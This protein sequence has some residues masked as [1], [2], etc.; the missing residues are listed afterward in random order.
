MSLPS[1]PRL[2]AVVLLGAALASGPTARAQP[3]L[4]AS[5]ASEFVG[6]VNLPGDS[7]DSILGLLERWTGKDLLRAQGLPNVTLT[8][9]LKDR[10]PK[11]QGVQALETLL[12]LNGIAVTPLGDRFLKVTP[13]NVAK[14]ESPEF[15][16]GST[17]GLPPSG[18]VASKLFQ[19]Q[20]LQVAEFMP[21]TAGLLNPAAGSPPII[22]DKANAALITDSITTLQRIET[23]V[24]RLD[25]PIL[26]STEPKF[27]PLRHATAADVVNRM[28]T[29]LSGP[30]A[31][32][33]GSATTYNADD[34]TN[35]LVL[36]TDARQHVFF[37]SLIAKLDVQ[38]DPNTRNAVIYLKHGSAPDV[39]N[40]LT[41]VVTG[42]M[43][44][45]RSASGSSGAQRRDVP[46]N[47]PAPAPQP[48]PL[49]ATVPALSL[50]A[51]DAKQFSP[52]LTIIPEERTNAII[53]SG[54]RD[55]IQL[56]ESLI[57]KIDTLL[58][59]VRIEV[60]IA[61]VTLGNNATSG[62]SELGL[63]IAGDKLVGF[64]GIGAGIAVREGVI[65]S[66]GLV[67]SGPYD[68]AAQILLATTPRKNIANILSVPTLVTTHN[69]KGR[70]FVGESRPVISSYLNEGTTGGG[71]NAGYRSTVNQQEIG[72]EL[73]VTPL[74][75]TD[76]SVQLEIEQKVEDILGEIEIDGNP[77]PRV[78]VRE[79]NSFVSVRSG[80]VIVL[81]GLQ[82]TSQTRTTSRLGPVPIIGDLL[83]TRRRDN[84]RT[85]LVFFL[86][87]TVLTNTSVDNLPALRQIDQ[88][89]ARQRDRIRDAVGV[90][91]GS[92]Q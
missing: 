30:L 26:A 48:Q 65:S 63:Q 18:R 69:R 60:V 23:L 43:N 57:A 19:L 51:D 53:V 20:F 87:P 58:A 62:I 72:I 91:L 7:V 2:F 33:L 35:Q 3:T 34:R 66:P 5:D 49:V 14:A 37:D 24:A 83:G 88:L 17:L 21:Q 86:R 81:G 32:M 47:A 16:D 82:R 50:G 89:P 70:I 77:Q 1:L 31:N 25:R 80:E 12:G 79:T 27:Y 6:P 78:G 22:F 29:I 39:A 74:I 13:L 85:D 54:T 10:V 11:A 40:V 42:Q 59:Q 56:I 28:R 36:V 52:L 15:I 9:V 67:G 84:T 68:L 75:G 71:T 76:G 61:E 45:V 55:D 92:G 38:S 90:P 4:P 41:Q 73:I 44:A 46:P 8:L 64:D